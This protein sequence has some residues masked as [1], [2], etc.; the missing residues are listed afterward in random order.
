MQ[1]HS[2]GPASESTT[3]KWMSALLIAADVCTYWLRVTRNAFIGIIG[4][5]ETQAHEKERVQ[6]TSSS[7]N[8]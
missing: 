4:T 3:N 5:V 7:K 6:S 2:L 8:Y 1:L